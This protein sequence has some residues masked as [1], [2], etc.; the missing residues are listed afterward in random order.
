[1]ETYKCVVCSYRENRGDT[2]FRGQDFVKW[3]ILQR[4]L[5]E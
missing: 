2:R 3:E 5:N 4:I 1:M